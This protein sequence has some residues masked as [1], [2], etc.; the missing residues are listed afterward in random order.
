M[1]FTFTAGACTQILAADPAPFSENQKEITIGV[2]VPVIS[3][4]YWKADIQGMQEYADKLNIKLQIQSS[5]NNSEFQEK[6]LENMIA[7]DVDAIILAAV[8][9]F[10]IMD[11]VKKCNDAGIPVIYNSRILFDTNQAQCTYGVA[12]NVSELASMGADWLINYAT[13]NDLSLNVLELCGAIEDSHTTYCK[14][15]FAKAYQENP[16]IFVNVTKINGDWDTELIYNKTCSALRENPD[17]NCIILHSDA[18]LPAVQ[19]ALNEL[20]RYKTNREKGHIILA[21]I[22]GEAATLNSLNDGY[23]DVVM[24]TPIYDTAKLSVK[25]AYD[26]ICGKPVEGKEH[27]LSG[28]LID[29]ENFDTAAY[30]AFGYLGKK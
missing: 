17:I 14:Q 16:N 30:Q 15:S 27:L 22:G 21:A 12:Y 13:E 20:G 23:T 1:L 24:A 6:Q 29:E 11:S 4:D 3:E 10:S 9:I 8:N 7:H 19:Y 5:Q 2:L 28:F 25:Y 26:I 18:Y